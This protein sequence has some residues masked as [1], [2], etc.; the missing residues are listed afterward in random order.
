[1]CRPCLLSSYIEAEPIFISITSISS[2]LPF[3]ER[4]NNLKSVIS[5]AMACHLRSASVPSNPLSDGTDIQDQLRS[6]K[7][8]MSSPSVTI[9]IVCGG[10]TELMSM[11]SCIDELTCLTSSSQTQQRKAVEDKLERSLVLL[12]LCSVMQESF[13]E[14]RT[15]VEEVQLSLK[16]VDGATV[17]TKVQ[18]YARLARKAQRLCKSISR[19]GGMQHHQDDS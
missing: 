14:L 5:I 18:S 19:H 9:Q 11:Y 7:A 2:P 1:M 3:P 12:D 15:S 17:H 13:T 8:V 6:L 4:T 16:R 10:L